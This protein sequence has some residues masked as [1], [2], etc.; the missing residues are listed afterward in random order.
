MCRILKKLWPAALSTILWPQRPRKQIPV[1]PGLLQQFHRKRLPLI[2]LLRPMPIPGGLRPKL[3]HLLKPGV[4]LLPKQPRRLR[5]GG[6][7]RIPGANL[8]RRPICL[9]PLSRLP[10]ELPVRRRLPL[11]FPLPLQLPLRRQLPP[12][13]H[14]A[15]PRLRLLLPGARHR[16]PPPGA[17]RP[18]LLLLLLLRKPICLR[19]RHRPLR[20]LRPHNSP[21]RTLP[22]ELPVRHPLYRLPPG[23]PPPVPGG[24]PPIL[25]LL[26][27][28]LICRQSLNNL[29]PPMKTLPLR[30][31]MGLR[32]VL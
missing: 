10:G 4:A 27:H 31:V 6:P 2:P 24:N 7:V 30:V 16:P 19:S 28:K 18:L 26:R 21:L 3:R 20:R 14:G 5:P 13:V 15:V 23:D 32:S 25:L 17:N 12:I 22:G 9:P 29:L 1:F 11:P 8:N